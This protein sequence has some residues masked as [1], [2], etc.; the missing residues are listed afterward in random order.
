MS[1]VGGYSNKVLENVDGTVIGI[2]ETDFKVDTIYLNKSDKTFWS[3]SGETLVQNT[4]EVI[5]EG[6]HILSDNE[7]DDRIGEKTFKAIVIE[8]MY[9]FEDIDEGVEEM[10]SYIDP[11]GGF[12]IVRNLLVSGKGFMQVNS[13]G[14]RITQVYFQ[15]QGEDEFTVVFLGSDD[16]TIPAIHVSMNFNKFT[17]WKIRNKYIATGSEIENFRKIYRINEI[18]WELNKT[19]QEMDNLL[20]PYGG[21][22]IV[23]NDLKYGKAFLACGGNFAVQTHDGGTGVFSALFLG[24]DDGV[25]DVNELVYVIFSKNTGI[26]VYGTYRVL[27]EGDVENYSP[28][29]LDL[30]IFENVEREDTPIDP[31]ELATQY[32]KYGGFANMLEKIR[33]DN[34]FYVTGIPGGDTSDFKMRTT[35]INFFITEDSIFAIFIGSDD[36]AAAGYFLVQLYENNGI[37]AY[38]GWLSVSYV[39]SNYRLS[40]TDG[41]TLDP[42]TMGLVLDALGVSGV[43]SLAFFAETQQLV[44]RIDGCFPTQLEHTTGKLTIY[45]SAFKNGE[46]STFAVVFEENVGITVTLVF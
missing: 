16:G 39:E 35:P 5:G 20:A 21:F 10:N 28:V 12:D 30:P 15:D 7:V 31:T 44:L 37:S 36:S 14:Y 4:Y 3:L 13:D 11:Y 24:A 18:P 9:V 43:D 45:Y 40:L 41:L 33:K 32:A 22:D 23:Q 6:D 29:V 26:T 38:Q 25:F 19:K 17:G 8:D 46:Q 42:A 27:Q 1:G 34:L 2:T